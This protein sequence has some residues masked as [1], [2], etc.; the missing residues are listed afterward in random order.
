MDIFAYATRNKLRFETD[1]GNLT[2]ED[3][4]DLPLT[5]PEGQLSIDVVGKASA[6]AVKDN[7]GN[8]DFVVTERT[9]DE[10]SL[11]IRLKIL[12]YIRDHK[13]DY[14]NRAE[15]AAMS[16]AKKQQILEVIKKKKDEDLESKGIDELE[17]MLDEL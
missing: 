7:D 4:W 16:K 2:V 14:A 15:K 6:K 8:E 3:I 12:E 1:K 9:K 5:A 11:T 13:V 10:S 17:K